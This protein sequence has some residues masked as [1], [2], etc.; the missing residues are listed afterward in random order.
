[1]DRTPGCNCSEY[2]LEQ[3]GCQCHLIKVLVWP[4]GYAD[5]GGFKVLVITDAANPHKEAVKAFGPCAS[6]YRIASYPSVIP[7]TV[8]AAAANAYTKNDNS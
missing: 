8:S 2:Q 4:H 7:T 1:M 6:V 3:V 5:E